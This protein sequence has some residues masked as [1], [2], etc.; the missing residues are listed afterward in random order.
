MATIKK[1]QKQQ[2]YEKV[3]ATLSVSCLIDADEHNNIFM[4]K[5]EELGLYMQKDMYRREVAI[6]IHL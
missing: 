5:I 4:N 1:Q 3:T 6:A 2:S